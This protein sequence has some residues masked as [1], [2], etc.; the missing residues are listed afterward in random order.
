VREAEK[1]YTRDQRER[2][3]VIVVIY[4]LACSQGRIIGEWHFNL[5]S[6]ARP[7]HGLAYVLEHWKAWGSSKRAVREHGGAWGSGAL[8]SGVIYISNTD[9]DDRILIQW[10]NDLESELGPSR[11]QFSLTRCNSNV[12]FKQ[13][14]GIPPRQ[15]RPSIDAPTIVLSGKIFC[16]DSAEEHA[17]RR[18]S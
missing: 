8:G 12:S 9:V 2:F 14:N 6:L 16:E 13:T 10:S 1:L 5:A 15:A 7:P 17:V 18:I 4:R 3:R 11:P